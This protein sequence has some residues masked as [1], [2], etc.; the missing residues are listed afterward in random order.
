M[1]IMEIWF[2]VIDYP[3]YSVSNLGNIKN[4]TTKKLL[5][6]SLHKSGYLTVQLFS[7]GKR[8]GF[9]LHR[10]VAQAFLGDFDDTK[11]IDH[12]D[13]NKLNNV[14]ENLRIVS[15]LESV[16]NRGIWG[17]SKYK[18]AYYSEKRKDWRS[19][20]RV[21]KKNISLGCY[22]TE[23]ECAIAYNNYIEDNCLVG[24]LKNIILE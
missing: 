5:K 21:N 6:P 16:L 14:L 12:I 18:G 23:L 19:Q 2:V 10:L 8:K 3:N 17:K 24:Y 15:P 9:R 20:I 1:Y 13:R 4:N 22:K 11:Y 7:N